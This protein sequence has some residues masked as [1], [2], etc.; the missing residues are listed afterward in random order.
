MSELRPL[1]EETLLEIEGM[2][3]D[4]K[5]RRD[6]RPDSVVR[7]LNLLVGE[8]RRLKERAVKDADVEE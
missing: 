5:S 7:G 8:V 2:I 1:T 4:I 3:D 6:V